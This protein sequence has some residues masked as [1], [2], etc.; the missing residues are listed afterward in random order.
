[1]LFYRQTN[2]IAHQVV[3]VRGLVDTDGSLQFARNV[4][5]P[6]VI[7]PA[8]GQ[9]IL[10]VVPNPNFNITGAPA[11]FVVPLAPPTPVPGAFLGTGT[12]ALD[13]EQ[14][15]G[16]NSYQPGFGLTLG[17]RFG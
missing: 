15:K 4:L 17:W 5:N 10:T 6:N 13:T 1:F 2:P 11:T 14:V 16:P 12:P 9:T 8:T 7:D 3:A